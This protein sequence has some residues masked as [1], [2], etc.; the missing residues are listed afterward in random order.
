MHVTLVYSSMGSRV[1]AAQMQPLTIAALAGLTPDDI[2]IRFFDD[3]IEE[4]E[5]D[6]P[7]D[8]VGHLRADL[9]AQGEL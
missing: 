8:L 2:D 5:Y 7:T 6:A 1:R 4:V 9:Y 3:R